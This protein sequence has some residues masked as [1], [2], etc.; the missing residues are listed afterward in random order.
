MRESPLDAACQS[1]RE[2]LV[3]H[4]VPAPDAIFLLG[5]GVGILP[6][7]LKAG[8]RM[9]L[10]RAK[11]APRIWGEA[12]LHWGDFH[13]LS[14]WLLD[15]APLE[16]EPSDPTW[17]R[18]FPIWL[19][20]ASGASAMIHT[21][22][23]TALDVEG[24]KMLEPG[25]LALVTDHVN[26]SG[27]TPLIGLAESHLGPMFPDQTR[28][29]DSFLRRSAL[30]ACT[31]LGIEAR[32]A[33]VACTVGPTLDTPAERRFFARVGAHVAVQD[34][35]PTLIAAAHAGLGT[36]E[37][38]VITA[39]AS[40]AVDVAQIAAV[41]QA[42][43]PALDDLLWQLAADVQREVRARLDEDLA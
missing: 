15:D 28:L 29:H 34:L 19:A 43:A 21:S 36:L 12:L 2:A 14:V 30:Q 10:A 26:L 23:G 37:I 3:A 18:P 42:I 27:G 1:A 31:K 40:D 5:T 11:G 25:S 4:G 7:R 6:G 9:P 17:A 20:A 24:E 8:G 41:S 38:S 16:L 32:E 33:I 22:A 35:A 39:R 13:G